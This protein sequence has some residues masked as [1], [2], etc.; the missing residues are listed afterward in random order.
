MNLRDG[1]TNLSKGLDLSICPSKAQTHVGF[2]LHT[3]GCQHLNKFNLYE[4]R[5]LYFYNPTNMSC[6]FENGL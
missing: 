6:N 3:L 1:K 4:L 5:T 2:F